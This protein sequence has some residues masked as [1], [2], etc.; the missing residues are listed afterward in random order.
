MTIS[1]SINP[2]DLSQFMFLQLN[3]CSPALHLTYY[4]KLNKIET[5]FIYK[6]IHTYSYPTD[7]STYLLD[8]MPLI[9]ELNENTPLTLEIVDQ[10]ISE[11]FVDMIDMMLEN[12]VLSG[13][14][15]KDVN[16]AIN[17]IFGFYVHPWRRGGFSAYLCSEL[18]DYE[19]SDDCLTELADFMSEEEMESPDNL[20]IYALGYAQGDYTLSELCPDFEERYNAAFNAQQTEMETETDNESN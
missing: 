11:R 20:N 14:M 15:K 3:L 17:E 18:Y 8:R 4:G 19:L 6:F 10:L 1:L 9:N 7:Y 2:F 13:D 16:R 12:Y 5:L